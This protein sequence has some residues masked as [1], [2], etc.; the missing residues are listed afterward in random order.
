MADAGCPLDVVS[1]HVLIEGLC[2]IREFHKV[3][4]I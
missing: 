1:Y 4:M 3:E 2:G